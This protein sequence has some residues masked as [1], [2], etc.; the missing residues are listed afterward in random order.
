MM[1]YSPQVI[2]WQ[3]KAF[4]QIGTPR[5]DYFLFLCVYWLLMVEGPTLKYI[6]VYSF[7]NMTFSLILIQNAA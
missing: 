1:L 4:V 3:K 6:L 7:Q 5:N 2:L